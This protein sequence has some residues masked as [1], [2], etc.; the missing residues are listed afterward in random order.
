MYSLGTS[1][2]ID[3]IVL[4]LLYFLLKSD[5]QKE[6]FDDSFN[7]EDIKHHLESIKNEYHDLE[8]FNLRRPR[9]E[10]LKRII[11]RSEEI[12]DGICSISLNII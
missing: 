10:K 3:D 11:E 8:K 9:R 1:L 4:I 2:S 7:L 6:F 5:D 12:K